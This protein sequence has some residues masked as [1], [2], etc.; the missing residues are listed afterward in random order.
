MESAKKKRPAKK[1]SDTRAH[2][3][4]EPKAL[5]FDFGGTLAFLDYDLLAREFSRDARP[6]DALALE[7]AEYQG[8]AA[9]D[10]HLMGGATD[11]IAAYTHFF[12]GWMEAA[13]I[14]LEEIAAYGD[15]F[16][17][18]HGEA[19]LWRVVRPGTMEALERLKSA[20]IKLA[21][22]SNAEGQIE[23]DAKR[24]GL[25]HF[26]DVIIDSHVVGVAKPDPRIFQIALE[27]L[28]V[29]PED[30]RF[31]GDI[32]SVDI[33]GARAAGIEAALIDQHDR[34]SWVDHRKIRHV[35]DLHPLD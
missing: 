1:V 8:R 32:Y 4:R 14:P 24:F 33:I 31:A 17:R 34:Y 6:L 5:L 9:I 12:A 29:A 15:H 3:H 10:R 30:A 22:V 28:G 13:G 25:H 21:I 7:H 26:F 11:V 35:A 19:S 27:R 2:K 16:R 23:S 20:G 18:L